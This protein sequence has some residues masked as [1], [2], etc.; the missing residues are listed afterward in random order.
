LHQLKR[1]SGHT[2][3][4]S[5]LTPFGFSF[6]PDV[7]AILPV[8]ECWPVDPRVLVKRIDP[9]GSMPFARAYAAAVDQLARRGYGCAPDPAAG[10]GEPRSLVATCIVYRAVDGEPVRVAARSWARSS[11][12]RSRWRI[13]WPARTRACACA[14]ARSCV[15]CS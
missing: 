14:S 12:S 2:D 8:D 6:D 7:D 3:I 5:M 13:A 10:D 1:V 11:A 15:S 9:I 4:R